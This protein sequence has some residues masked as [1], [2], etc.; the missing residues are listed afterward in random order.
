MEFTINVWGLASGSAWEPKKKEIKEI[1]TKEY[2]ILPPISS[3]LCSRG[4][5]YQVMGIR[6][7][8]TVNRVET[9]LDVE[10]VPDPDQIPA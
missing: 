6:L 7:V 4:L 2:P 8:D 10:V 9:I 5:K 3:I 1:F